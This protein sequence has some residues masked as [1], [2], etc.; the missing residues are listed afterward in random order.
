MCRHSFP[1]DFTTIHFIVKNISDVVVEFGGYPDDYREK[2]NDPNTMAYQHQEI[3]SR[4]IP[5]ICS[6]T[7]FFDHCLRDIGLF[8]YFDKVLLTSEFSHDVHKKLLTEHSGS[9]VASTSPTEY[10]DK[11]FSEKAAIT[12]SALFD[13]FLKIREQRKTSERSSV[14]LFV[15][16]FKN[17]HGSVYSLFLK[18]G[19]KFLLYLKSFLLYRGAFLKELSTYPTLSDI[20]LGIKKFTTD[21]NCRLIVKN[22]PKN[23]D[24]FHRLLK[25]A[26]DRFIYGLDDTYY[27]N[28]TSADI[29]LAARVAIHFRSLAVLESVVAGVPAVVISLPKNNFVRDSSENPVHQA[30]VRL[31]LDRRPGNL[32]SYRG[33]VWNIPWYDFPNFIANNP[34][35]LAA[36]ISALHHASLQS[37]VIFCDGHHNI[38]PLEAKI[39]LVPSDRNNSCQVKRC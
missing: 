30:L 23:D 26:S 20:V 7:H 9:L 17:Y 1:T 3:R 16:Q 2:L 19:P 15:P 10:I 39:V 14:V 35:S 6:Y 13:Q 32:T 37:S 18:S 12:G 8:H 11:V 34:N 31:M 33:C 29:L 4:G 5:L 27:P 25:S 28:F 24:T 36:R 38:V 22:R 21:D